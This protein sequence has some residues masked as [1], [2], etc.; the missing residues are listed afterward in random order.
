MHTTSLEFFGHHRIEE[1]LMGE[2]RS[3]AMCFYLLACWLSLGCAICSSQQG[4][5]V[6]GIQLPLSGPVASFGFDCRD[7]FEIAA[8]EI[9]LDLRK[10]LR[11]AYEDDQVT[12]KLA[13]SAS[14]K[15]LMDKDLIALVTFSSNIALAVS[16]IAASKR[17]PM[18]ALSGHP[19]LRS[20]NHDVYDH[21]PDY[22]LETRHYIEFVAEK[23]P[24]KISIVTLEH[25]Y[26][27]ALRDLFRSGVQQKHMS[28]VIDET[29]SGQIDLR[30]VATRIIQRKSDF[31]FLNLFEPH[32]SGLVRILRQQRYAGPILT[33][34]GNVTHDAIAS[35]GPE[36][37][38]GITFFTPNYRHQSFLSKVS[39]LSRTPQ[40]L[41]NVFACYIGMKR[42]LTAV[43]TV[44]SAGN[45][46]IEGV[47]EALP[48][49][50]QLEVD[51]H[52]FHT[53]NQGIQFDFIRGDSVKGKIEFK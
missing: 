5:K 34:A 40:D 11:F 19:R 30:T 14:H 41:G 20:E 39:G 8:S 3:L 25:D 10:G 52:L 42:F 36:L 31:V 53:E 32:F 27:L 38:D 21:W 33:L 50:K 17:V 47:R 46:S 2:L 1:F 13:V 51:G 22:E 28:V 9:S 49:V 12:P 26:T 18:L 45:L 43:S 4:P 24:S 37:S 44:A 35:L 16:P 7:G 23:N 29:V 6:I 15:F 48:K